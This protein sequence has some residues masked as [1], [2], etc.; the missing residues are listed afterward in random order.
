MLITKYDKNGKPTWTARQGFDK[1]MF[2]YAAA[3]A[4]DDNGSICIT[5]NVS[6]LTTGS[7]FPPDD[8]IEKMK[9]NQIVT[10]KYDKN[11]ERKWLTKY[12]AAPNEAVS[13]RYLLTDDSANIYVVGTGAFVIKYDSEGRLMWK[14]QFKHASE[15]AKHLSRIQLQ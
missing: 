2:V 13:S 14:K 9:M 1:E 15:L 11:G 12:K 10:L 8:M 5:G 3:M 6:P 7:G 4:V